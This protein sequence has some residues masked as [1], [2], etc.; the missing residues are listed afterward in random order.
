MLNWIKKNWLVC[1]LVLIIVLLL[2]ANSGSRISLLSSNY[3]SDFT[4]APSFAPLSATKMSLGRTQNIA[5]SDSSERLVIKDTSLSLQ[6]KDVPSVI[7]QIESAAK[8]LGGYLVDSSLSRPESAASGNITVRVPEDKLN[9]ALESFRG[10]AVKVVSEHISGYDVTDQYVDLQARLDVLNKTKSKFEEILAK[11]ESSSS[12]QTL[13]SDILNVQRELINLQDQIDQVK[14]Q[15]KY[16]EQSAKLSKVTVYLSTDDISLPYLPD[17]S[18]RPSVV[19]KQAVR[20]LVGNLRGLGSLI[21]WLV[22][23]SPLLVPL[24]ALVFWLNKRRHP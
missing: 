11:A 22:V 20:S 6:V 9:Q 16:Y 23:Y 18:W 7:S 3:E 15:Q 19:F 8:S 10:L 21:I 13:I 24:L 5:P 12:G 17:Q 1:L 14:G 2:K 4:S